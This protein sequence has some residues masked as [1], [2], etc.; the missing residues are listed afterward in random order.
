M[1]DLRLKAYKKF[2]SMPNPNFGP[3]LKKLNFDDYVYYKK[4]TDKVAKTW[5]DVPQ[6]IKETFEKNWHSRS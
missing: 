5:D 3:S 4:P 6:E 1:L 2:K